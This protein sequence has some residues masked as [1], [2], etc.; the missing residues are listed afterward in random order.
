MENRPLA[1]ISI[2]RAQWLFTSWTKDVLIYTIVL[3]L[4]VEYVDAIVI[5]SF[6][7]SM[8]TAILLKALLDVILGLE[9]RVADYFQQRSGP[10]S[11]I[12]RIVST[13]L[14]LFLS[15][16][17]ILEVVDV[18]FGDHVELG[19]FLSVLSLVLVMMITREIVQRIYVSLGRG[20]SI[21]E[22]SA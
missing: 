10:I 14:I 21:E 8:L 15:K 5:D 2:T 11:K 4:F 1:E 19:G 6:T 22:N 18:V 9:H 13:W 3:N 7:I 16:F 20:Q 12:L 17:V